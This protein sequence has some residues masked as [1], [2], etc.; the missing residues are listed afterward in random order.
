MTTPTRDPNIPVL[1]ADRM[2]HYEHAH[3]TTLPTRTHTLIRVDG[4]AFGSYTK[5]LERPFDA[6][7]V[8][9]MNTT[10]EALCEHIT[11]VRLAFVQSDEISLLLTDFN[12]PTTQP[13]MGGTTAKV[14]S[15]SAA[16]A[17]AAFNRARDQRHM[18]SGEPGLPGFALF[19][20]RAWTIDDPAEVINYFIWRQRDAIKNSI[21][22]AASTHF[23]HAR[24]N[25]MTS[26]QRRDLLEIEAGIRWE[27]DYPTG[28]RQGRIVCRETREETVTYTRRDTGET[29]SQDVGRRVWA[30]S[31]APTFNHEPDGVM[32]TVMPTFTP[33]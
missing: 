20:S 19:D 30:T 22:M 23:S 1:L 28:C 4:K 29:H 12:T 5:G 3:R 33:A 26:T 18:A 16:I 31:D 10:A 7:F 11:G 13:W 17:T 21:S 15:L 6:G 8:A 14:I 24:L 25:N 32:A 27:T 2:K 9:D